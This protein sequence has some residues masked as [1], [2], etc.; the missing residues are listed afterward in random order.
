[1]L[2]RF[3]QTSLFKEMIILDSDGSKPNDP[4]ETKAKKGFIHRLTLIDH[5]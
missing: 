3:I 4:W 5:K 1:M 2:N